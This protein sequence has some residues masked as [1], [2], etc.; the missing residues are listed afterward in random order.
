M[1]V[2]PKFSVTDWSFFRADF[3]A[4]DYY[5]RLKSL[6]VSAAEMVPSDRWRDARSFG[7]DLLNISGP[8]MQKG[9]NRIENHANLL[10]EIKN[11]IDTASAA[12]I[13]YVIVFSGNRDGQPDD[14]GISQCVEG[15]R[16]VAP[17]AE[18]CR[19]TLLLEMLNSYDHADYQAD[20]G[21]YGFEVAREVESASVGVLYDIYHMLRMGDDVLKD[22][23][24]N[25]DIIHHIHIA[26][27]PNRT[28]ITENPE[29]NYRHIVKEIQGAGYDGYWGLE[30]LPGDDVF[31]EIES[32]VNLLNNS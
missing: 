32:A 18:S 12:G 16:K 21:A 30:F 26:D 14:E 4:E 5:S 20:H 23:L 17:Y 19:V 22:M 8:G 1:A 29:A 24:D 25:L 27:I 6:G 9:L 11:S 3:L 15:L 28:V 10:P 13:P 2:K 31:S 7:I